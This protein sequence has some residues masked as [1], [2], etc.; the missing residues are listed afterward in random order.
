MQQC[1]TAGCYRI[2]EEGEQ[3]CPTCR[4]GQ[5]D[6]LMSRAVLPNPPRESCKAFDCEYAGSKEYG[7]YCYKCFKEVTRHEANRQGKSFFVK[8]LVVSCWLCLS[9]Y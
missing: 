5:Y 8:M 1:I 2:P 3:L 7:G 6:N 4:Q 9:F